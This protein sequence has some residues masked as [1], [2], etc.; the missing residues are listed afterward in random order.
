MKK[1]G[2]VVQGIL[3]YSKLKHSVAIFNCFFRSKCISTLVSRGK[4]L[5]DIPA[6]VPFLDTRKYTSTFN[7]VRKIVRLYC[8]K[9][10]L[11]NL[12]EIFRRYYSDYYHYHYYYHHDY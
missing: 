5:R 9:L 4:I 3:L 2:S 7:K 11:S 8:S 10:N 6:T 12:T 1:D